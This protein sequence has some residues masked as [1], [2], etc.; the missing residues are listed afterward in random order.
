MKIV[1]GLFA[2]LIL[3]V[4]IGKFSQDYLKGNP[5]PFMGP[6]TKTVTI[7]GHDFKLEEAKTAKDKEVGLSGRTTLAKD[8]GMLF[9][10]D[11]PDLYPFWM[12]NMKVSIDIIYVKDG[13]IVTIFPDMQAPKSADEVPIIVKSEEPADTVIEIN[14][15]DSEKY[16][17]KNGDTVTIK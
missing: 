16:K 13:K 9:K 14:A 5:L 8:G 15:G 11:K 2:L 4:V 1:L 7:N 6:A 12:K 17:I 10:F 3:I